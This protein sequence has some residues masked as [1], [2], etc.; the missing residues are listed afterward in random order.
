M[1]KNRNNTIFYT[2]FALMWVFYSLNSRYLKIPYALL[3]R[4]VLLALLVLQSKRFKVPAIVPAFIIAT[5]PSILASVDVKESIVKILCFCVVSVG[6]SSFFSS[7]ES[8]DEFENALQIMMAVM[9]LFEIQSILAIV[10]GFGYG[11]GFGR[12]TGITTNSNT[13][14]GY[15]NLAYVAAYYWFERTRGSKKLFFLMIMVGSVWTCVLSGSRAGF[16]CLL[17]ITALIAL[18]QGNSGMKI[19]SLA[20]V[21]VVFYLMYSGALDSLNIRGL[22]GLT[23]AGGLSR[24]GLWEEGMNV[25]R[26]YPIFG[27]GYSTSAAHNFYDLSYGQYDF[28]NSYIT[29]LAE[30][31]VWGTAI[32]A[33]TVAL[34]SIMSVRMLKHFN[35][36]REIPIY[37]V[38]FLMMVTQLV[39][40][41]GES[42]LFAVGSTEACTFWM[43]FAWL[44]SYRDHVA[45]EFYRTL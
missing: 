17:I 37:M 13:L 26:Q 10:L 14:G 16:G 27:C 44:I 4:W 39:S 6:G 7:L 1:F 20:T 15:S 34:S 24:G 3:I 5:T 32:I 33:S 11:S 9:I 22:Q 38:V 36:G 30:T 8:E 42:F 2:F 45:M 21:L 12:A 19:L 25:W 31:G 43:L 18:L 40:A 28:H 29:L 35:Y 23:Q 41:Y